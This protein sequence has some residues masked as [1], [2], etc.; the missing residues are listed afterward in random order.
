MRIGYKIS[1]LILGTAVLNT[2]ILTGIGY[3][4]ARKQYFDG[5]D[6]Q[7]AAA[8][9]ALPRVIGEDYLGRALTDGNVPEEEYD[10]LVHLLNDLADRSGVFYLYVFVQDGGQVVHLAT[11]ASVAE[12][13]AE[14][15]AAFHEPYEEPPIELISTFADGKTRFAEYAD[16]FGAVPF[17]LRTTHRSAESRLRR[18]RRCDTERN[19]NRSR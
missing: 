15:W 19:P 1:W 17:D 11:S 8:A 6:R 9:A 13:A 18:R 4:A 10:H 14:D 16:E 12:R 7:L 3:S 2:G 5:V